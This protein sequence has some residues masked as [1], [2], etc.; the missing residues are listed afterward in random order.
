MPIASDPRYD[1]ILV[2]TDQAGNEIER[3]PLILREGGGGLDFNIAYTSPFAGRLPGND[4]Q[5]NDNTRY[6][7]RT[8]RDWRGGLGQEFAYQ[9]TSQFSQ[10]LADTRFRNQLMLPPKPQATTI[11]GS[12]DP[13]FTPA[14]AG[15]VVSTKRAKAEWV[16]GSRVDGEGAASATWANQNPSTAVAQASASWTALGVSNAESSALVSWADY[17]NTGVNVWNSIEDWQYQ[18][19]GAYGALRAY[20]P[21]TAP[22][23]G[24]YSS[25]NLY[26]Y[27]ESV[28]TQS[29]RIDIWTRDGSNNPVSIV[30]TGYIY[31]GSVSTGGS[32]VNASMSGVTLTAGTVYLISVRMTA[33]QVIDPW[34]GNGPV[35]HYYWGRYT[36]GSG[37]GG[38]AFTENQSNTR[39][40]VSGAFAFTMLGVKTQ[41]RLAQ[42]ILA[43]ASVNATQLKVQIKATAWS[44]SPTLTVRLCTDSGGAIGTVLQS[45]SAS[46]PGGAFT[47]ATFAISSQAIT[48]GAYYWI[49]L[50]VDGASPT[51]AI[52]IS[53][54]RDANA[55]Y[56]DGA[57]YSQ[58]AVSGGSWSALAGVTGDFYFAVN[59]GSAGNFPFFDGTR[60]SQVRLA[61]SFYAPA[62]VNVTEIKVPLAQGTWTGSPTLTMKLCASSGGLPS[63]VLKSVTTTNPSSGFVWVTLTVS[64]QALTAGEYYWLV[65][66]ADAPA[67]SDAISIGWWRD[68]NNNYVDG[69]GFTQPATAGAWGAWAGTGGDFFFIFNTGWPGSFPFYTGMVITKRRL[70]HSISGDG[71]TYTTLKLPLKSNTWVGSPAGTIGIYTA[72]SGRPG[73]VLASASFSNPGAAFTWVTATFGA[74]TLTNGARYF[75]VVEVDAPTANDGISISWQGSSVNGTSDEIAAAQSQSQ[76]LLLW[77]AT[78]GPAVDDFYYLFGTLGGTSKKFYSHEQ[79]RVR[80]AES[81]TP[82]ASMTLTRIRFYA[83]QINRSGAATVTLYLTDNSSGSPGSTIAS[84]SLPS[85]MFNASSLAWVDVTISAALTGGTTYWLVV[86][87]DAPVVGDAV[88]IDIGVD[89]S[90]GY[91][92]AFKAQTITDYTAG[93][94]GSDAADMFLIFNNGNAAPVSVTSQPVL[95]GGSWWM[96]SDTGIYRFGEV[97]NTNTGLENTLSPD[98]SFIPTNATGTFVADGYKGRYAYKITRTGDNGGYLQSSVYGGYTAGNKFRVSA[99]VKIL[100]GSVSTAPYV[101]LHQYDSSNN[102][103][104]IIGSGFADPANPNWQMIEFTAVLSGA[105]TKVMAQVVAATSTQSILIDDVRITRD[106]WVLKYNASSRVTSFHPFAGKLY[107]ALGDGDDMVES[108]DGTTWAA[109]A[110]NRKY[111][112]LKAFGGF[113]YCMKSVGG[114]SAL[115][116]FNGSAWVTDLTVATGDQALTGLAGFNNE[117]V[118]LGTRSMFSLSS[119][120]VYQ[121]FDYTNE[122]DQD[123]GK[124]S[125]VWMVNGML[126]VPVRNG[127]NAYDGVKM[128]AVGPDQN[129]G[130]PAGEQGRISAMCGSKTWL[131][132]AVDAGPGGIS[133][134]YAYNGSGWHCIAKGSAAGRRIRAVGIETVTSPRGF[135]RLWWFEDATPYYVEFP[136][137]TDNPYQ[138]AGVKF[139]NS[140]FVTSSWFGGELALIQKDFNAIA[141]WSAGCSSGQSVQVYYEVDQSGIWNLAGT[142]TI[143]P[144]QEFTLGAPTMASKV[145]G[146]GSTVTT[147]NLQSGLTTDMVAGQFLRVGHDVAQVASVVSATQFTIALPLEAAPAAGTNIKTSGPAGRQIRYKLVLATT[148][149]TKTPKINRVSIRTM[150]VVLAKARITLAP[151]IEDGMRLRTGAEQ[152]PYTAAQLRTKL[153]EWVR[154]I[155]PFIMVDMFGQNWPVKITGQSES[156]P[157]RQDDQAKGV[158]TYRSSMRLEMDEV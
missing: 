14:Q 59:T 55:L 145:V 70:T 91:A 52:N 128:S 67:G 127:L 5:D 54:Q 43:P 38:S 99:W 155:K 79:S 131:F 88:N 118:I 2:D 158:M 77:S 13:Q 15:V 102:Y 105:G 110:G 84:V 141:I 111:T 100:S 115:A 121:I 136:N 75:I 125:L 48:A 56:T 53:W 101:G 45:A 81:V 97:L 68:T 152:Y 24:S 119:A 93:A 31:A 22:Y 73:T 76:R 85:G 21:F 151:R 66:E 49:V 12:T 146:A 23:T 138:F 95:F 98:W 3:L 11:N 120:Y 27:K 94:W 50:E 117:L 87:C 60:K 10:S 143:S 90:G 69:D 133:G 64:S 123:N 157:V 51:D 149:E 20:Q 106:E 4:I 103:I 25:L 37:F 140:G 28:T 144:Y 32:W 114:A 19:N 63:T 142:V 18:A 33:T 82:S 42:R 9:E 89:T 92:G 96:A 108:S 132:A 150:G 58:T 35:A 109:T 61:Q 6:N 135:T 148:D 8:Q 74:I 107:A 1:L 26:L 80:W 65:L 137:V 71:N 41:T 57:A 126:H 156:V 134:V 7:I 30:S 46:N 78:T 29:L 44:G 122:E 112:Y 86:D 72:S 154:R 36:A 153:Y 124:N 113:L 116:Y 62:S 47:W 129:E 147:I 130:L 34:G 139:A 39:T 83:Q 17:G 40:N 16:K 104:G